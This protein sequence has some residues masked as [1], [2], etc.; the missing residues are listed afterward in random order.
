MLSYLFDQ[1]G[2]VHVARVVRKY[3]AKEGESRESVFHLLRRSYRDGGKI[4]HKTLGNV[5]LRVMAWGGARQVTR[6]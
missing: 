6:P 2:S 4:R 3:Q 1:E 5:A